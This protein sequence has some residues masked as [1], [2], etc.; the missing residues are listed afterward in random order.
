[1]Q[2]AEQARPQADKFN[3]Q[4]IDPAARAVEQNARP[5]ADKAINQGIQPGAQVSRMQAAVLLT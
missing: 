3:E 2:V 1:M 5:L 4:A